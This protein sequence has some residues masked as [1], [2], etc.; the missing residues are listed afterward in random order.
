M[1]VEITRE[2]NPGRIVSS[3]D[4]IIQQGRAPLARIGNGETIFG[5]LAEGTYVLTAVSAD[6]YAASEFSAQLW[7]S[8]PLQLVVKK[9]K[10]YR[11]SVSSPETSTGWLL[12][13]VGE[14]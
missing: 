12:R 13:L 5:S 9:G 3:M 1:N 7:S 10:R 11:L 6:P 2:K 8:H 4:V 14:E